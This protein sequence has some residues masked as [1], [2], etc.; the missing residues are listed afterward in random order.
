MSTT[1]STV[2]RTSEDLGMIEIE[3]RHFKADH[4]LLHDYQ[5]FSSDIL[6]GSLSGIAV[7]GF[8]VNLF[9]LTTPLTAY[10]LIA[11]VILLGVSVGLSLGHRYFSTK[12]FHYHLRVIR[13]NLSQSRQQEAPTYRE[14]R[15]RS[16]RIAGYCFATSTVTFF[17]GAI[18]LALAF[19]C[20]LCAAVH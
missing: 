10:L 17:A 18:A 19:I 4:E 1:A 8:L 6:R 14:R 2:T 15:T 7:V 20:C 16:Y 12:G 5:S 11:S 3:D 13:S 9:K